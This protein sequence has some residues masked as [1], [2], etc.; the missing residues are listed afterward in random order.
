MMSVREALIELL[1]TILDAL[2]TEDYDF[3]G[4]LREWWWCVTNPDL[5]DGPP[6]G[7]V[8]RESVAA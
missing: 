5:L 1:A 2:E 8:D 7:E 3:A 4:R 6:V